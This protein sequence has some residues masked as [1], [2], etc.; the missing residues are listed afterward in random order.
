MSA[1]EKA[2]DYGSLSLWL[3]SLR[4]ELVPRSPL[5]GSKSVD[6]A[7]VGAGYTGLWTA[8]YLLSAAPD[9]RI[10]LVEKEI[11]GFGAS[12]RNG[13]WCSALFA[14]SRH[15]IAKRYG[16]AAAIAMQSAMFDT[17]D[18]VGK[19]CSVEGI[20]AHFHKGGT[21]TL[22]TSTAQVE[23][24]RSA[25]E[26]DKAWGFTDED[27]RWL[28]ASDL[29]D[30][31]TV[32]GAL[33][34][35]FTPHCAR[36]HPARLA[37]GLARVVSDKG[38]SIYEGTTAL[39]VRAGRVVTTHGDVT[40]DIVV[41]ATEGYT[42][43]LRSRRRDLLPLYSLMIATEPLPAA[44]WDEIGCSNYET[45][46]DGRHLLIYAQRTADDRIAIGGRGAPY[47]Y[48]SST[49]ASNDRDRNVF[50][51]IR[52]VLGRLFPAARDAAV[53][54]EWGGALGVPRD[55]F[56]SVGFDRST[57]LAWAGG[58]VGDGVATTNLAGRTLADLITG[59]DTSLVRLPWVNHRSRRWEP[60]P[61]RWIEVNLGLRAMAYA[62]RLEERTGRATKRGAAMR[63]LIGI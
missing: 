18:E 36:I 42:H 25:V 63:R 12:G 46:D 55:W 39:D 11:A 9:M 56:T 57:G 33:G 37:R 50:D 14:A 31:V 38:V 13:G 54:H 41:R 28:D 27:S 8:Y 7:I 43:T 29:R 20:D 49:D 16:R 61:L 32:A 40:A 6:I 48:G 62:D 44:V 59:R 26:D 21:L 30:R 22:A 15:K 17:V 45:I 58:Y 5:P 60:E 35:H 24:V 1:P 34:A 51:A 53:T 4:D 3:D 19:V 47:H 2:P 10:A 52:A 23:R